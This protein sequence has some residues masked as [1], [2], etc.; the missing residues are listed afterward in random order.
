MPTEAG[1]VVYFSLRCLFEEQLHLEVELLAEQPSSRLFLGCRKRCLEL[2]TEIDDFTE[3]D[4]F[5]RAADVEHPT[6]VGGFI[7]YDFGS[8]QIMLGSQHG[9]MRCQRNR[10]DVVRVV[11][12]SLVG[13]FVFVIVPSEV[14]RQDS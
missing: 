7:R 8:P 10:R 3:G 2:G 11:L 1:S 4:A 6:V 9:F 13:G 5:I 14:V 12:A